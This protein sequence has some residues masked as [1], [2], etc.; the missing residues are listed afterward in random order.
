MFDLIGLFAGHVSRW[1]GWTT[2]DIRAIYSVKKQARAEGINVSQR[3]L[4]NH[5]DAVR[6]IDALSTA[7]GRARVRESL[8]AVTQGDRQKANRLFALLDAAITKRSEPVAATMSVG[9]AIQRTVED[10]NDD[11]ALWENRLAKLKPIRAVT[12]REASGV[13]SQMPMLLRLLDR[14]ER[15]TILES[16]SLNLPG[17]LVEAPSEVMAWLADMSSDAGLNQAALVFV[18]GALDRGA[19]PLGYWEFRRLRLESELSLPLSAF[20]D[21]QHPLLVAYALETAGQPDEAIQQIEAWKPTSIRERTTRSIMR[22]QIAYNTRD[23]DT[24]IRLALR[25]HEETGNP[26]LAISAARGMIARHTF[27]SRELH[28]DDLPTAFRLLIRTRDSLRSWGENSIEVI[29]LAVEAARLLNDPAR[30]LG[31]TQAEPDGEATATEAASLDLRIVRAIML[32]DNG[33]LDLARE[34]LTGEALEK[35]T[36]AH[37]RA[38]IA[39][40]EGDIEAVKAYYAEAL[41]G[42]SDYEQK[43]HFAVRLAYLG[44]VHPFVEEQRAAGNDEYADDLALIADAFG[45]T[46]GGL[47]RLIAAAHSSAR[48]SLIVSQVYEARGQADLQLRTLRASA[49]RLGD[50]DIWLATASLEKGVDRV[51]DG[52]YSANEA[53]RLAPDSWGAFART[54]GLL[55]DLYSRVP[56]WDRAAR[57]AQHLVRL[58]PE[59]ANAVWTLITCQHHA[60]ELD[61]AFRTWDTLSDR[62]RPVHRTHVMV[63]LSLYHQF[64]EVVASLEDLRDAASD[65]ARDEE[66]RRRIVGLLIL[67]NRSRRGESSERDGGPAESAPTTQDDG[68]DVPK[69]IPA[70]LIEDYFRDFPDG[71]IRRLSMDLSENVSILDQLEAAVGE[72][73]DTSELDEQVFRGNFPLG[74]ILLAHGGTLTEAVLSHAAGVRFA[75]AGLEDERVRAAESIGQSVVVDMTALFALSVLSPDARAVL[76]GAFS[77][78]TIAADQFRDAVAASQTIGRFGAAGPGLGRLRGPIAQRGRPGVEQVLDPSRIEQLVELIRPLER[79]ARPVGRPSLERPDITE[80]IWFAAA[81]TAGAVRS[82]WSDD[83]ALNR[84][85]ADLGV[86]TFSTIALVEVLQAQERISASQAGAILSQ[87]LV[88]RYV[89]IPFDPELYRRAMTLRE[90]APIAIASVIEYLSGRSANEVLDFAMEVAGSL[91]ADGPRLEAWVSACTRWLVKVSPDEPTRR[92]NVRVFA[93]RLSIVHWLLPQTFPFVDAGMRD[94]VDAMSELDP[95]VDALRPIYRRRRMHDEPQAALWLFELI[96]GVD[97][98]HRARLTALAFE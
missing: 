20:R 22:A 42:T 41:D 39:Q 62:E 30:A 3:V 48:L 52:I 35:G 38:L 76:M 24:S 68:S 65:W 88:E 98:P 8:M 13:W 27:G 90:D 28:S 7:E 45:D 77:G 63:W 15:R 33:I 54:R 67:P 61:E 46:E 21:S 64:G 36:A 14:G 2:L 18:N 79:Q 66:I 73:P 96:A 26:T 37:L 32:A 58:L 81:D 59:D 70:S 16:W 5:L 53:L 12:A 43:G 11:R 72:R 60:G 89:E 55:V 17:L 97:A 4:R 34:L 84:L 56:D 80:D 87:L 19:S 44:I 69:S 78:L 83:A 94:G 47:D 82:L 71:E 49:A 85:A 74:M 50:A 1:L 31:L 9:A 92:Q 51:A 95:I 6:F 40:T 57:E 86:A 10:V 29:S 91:T 75:S 25:A 93:N 23:F